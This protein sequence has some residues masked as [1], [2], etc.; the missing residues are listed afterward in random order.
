MPSFGLKGTQYDQGQLAFGDMNS[1][2]LLLDVSCIVYFG[3]V[4]YF[5]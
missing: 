3:T 5:I 2:L 1:V 4:H